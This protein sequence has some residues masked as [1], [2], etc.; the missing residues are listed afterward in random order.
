MATDRAHAF[1]LLVILALPLLAE[2]A[3]VTKLVQQT[4]TYMKNGL[5]LMDVE[6]VL[7]ARIMFKQFFKH[8]CQFT[9]TSFGGLFNWYENLACRCMC[10]VK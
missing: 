10:C 1:A 2:R 9:R 3:Q 6:L 8:F 4:L 5:K 7:T